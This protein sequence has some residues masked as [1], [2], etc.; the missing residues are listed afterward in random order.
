MGKLQRCIC[1]LGIA[2]GLAAWTPAVWAAGAS[3]QDATEEQKKS[4]QELFIEAKKHFDEKRFDEALEGFRASYDTVASPNSHLMVARTLRELDRLEEAFVTY[5]EVIKEAQ[6]AAK[7]DPKYEKAA[8]AATKELDEIRSRVAFVT[9]QIV[10]ATEDTQIFVNDTPVQKDQ[11]GQTMPVRVG[12]ITVSAKAPGKADY[13]VDVTVAG[14]TVTHTVDLAQHWAPPPPAEPAT[15][16]AEETHSVDLL[17]LDKRT[18]AYIAGGVGAA[19]VVTFGVFGAMN[20]SKYNSLDS[21]CPNGICPTDRNDDIDAGK[22]YQT[23]ANIGLVVG[24]VG[25]GTGTALYFLSDDEQ[26]REQPTTQVGVGPGSVMVR[27]TFQ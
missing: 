10:G 6:E 5:E 12:V 3:V 22:R 14:G 27:G 21:D 19:G 8:E 25:L 26:G 13:S 11:W 7:L 18:W 16:A 4:A 1:A 23:I 2:G 15:P 20:R 9:L 24:V 17:G